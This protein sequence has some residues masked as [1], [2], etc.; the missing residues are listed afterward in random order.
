MNELRS[1]VSVS[2]SI[3]SRYVCVAVVS[4]GCSVLPVSTSS[5]RTCTSPLTVNRLA[6]STTSAIAGGTDNGAFTV[7][8]PLFRRH[9]VAWSSTNAPSVTALLPS[10]RTGLVP[11]T[12]SVPPTF[13]V[14]PVIANDGTVQ[15][16][17]YV[18]TLPFRITPPTSVLPLSNTCPTSNRDPVRFR[19]LAPRTDKY[20]TITPPAI[21]Y[22]CVPLPS[23][24]TTTTRSNVVNLAPP[25]IFRLSNVYTPWYVFPTAAVVSKLPE[26]GSVSRSVPVLSRMGYVVSSV[27]PMSGST[28]SPFRPSS[29]SPFGNV[30]GARNTGEVAVRTSRC[31]SRV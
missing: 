13:T 17:G 16:P 25:A 27:S 7:T 10:I 26:A 6:F 9:S 19:T 14:L 31:A 18:T 8:T 11:V 15:L 4:S 20:G 22:V 21:V 12:R 5:S 24:F 29:T 1:T 23:P 3:A 30:C 2:T 28:S